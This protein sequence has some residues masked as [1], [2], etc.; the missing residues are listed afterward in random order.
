MVM[1]GPAGNPSLK[2]T[3]FETGERPSLEIAAPFY[4]TLVDDGTVT[5]PRIH[6][7]ILAA[8]VAKAAA[9]GAP[10]A[11]TADDWLDRSQNHLYEAVRRGVMVTNYY[12]ANSTKN[13]NG[14][15]AEA[16]LKLADMPT[17]RDIAHGRLVLPDYGRRVIN[18]ANVYLVADVNAWEVEDKMAEVLPILAVEREGLGTG[19]L[20]EL[21]QD[22]GRDHP[23]TDEGVIYIEDRQIRPNPNFDT[24][25]TETG[26]PFE[27]L[28]ADRGL[29]VSRG[30]FGDKGTRKWHA[31]AGSY[32]L[33]GRLPVPCREMGWSDPQLVIVSLLAELKDDRQLAAR[34]GVDPSR[35]WSTGQIDDNFGT[36]A[37]YLLHA[38]IND[39]EALAAVNL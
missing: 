27:L 8:D 28:D 39:E 32:R 25:L 21:W 33:G 29:A 35:L 18:A 11:E 12:P 9:I 14:R 6:D 26:N 10:D 3:Y 13:K 7:A 17:W 22:G 20:S 19:V 16:M 23:D 15:L 38:P 31:F 1:A 30:C 5:R 24:T 2:Q 34:H 37:D 36:N 4:E